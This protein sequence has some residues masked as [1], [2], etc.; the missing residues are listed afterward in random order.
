[1]AGEHG[2]MGWDAA[3]REK[4][5]EREKAAREREKERESAVRAMAEELHEQVSAYAMSG[6]GLAY[7]RICQRDVRYW[8]S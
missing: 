8:P 3:G 4:E 6:T 2:C 7:G 5:G 1:M